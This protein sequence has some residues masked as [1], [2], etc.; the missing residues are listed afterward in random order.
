M[1]TCGGKYVMDTM[2]VYQ[3][4]TVDACTHG[5]VQYHLENFKWGGEELKQQCTCMRMPP[6]SY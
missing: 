1:L 5:G 6:S 3:Y 4:Y 2:V